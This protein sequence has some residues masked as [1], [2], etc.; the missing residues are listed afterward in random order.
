MTKNQLT[1]R[2]RRMVAEQG[3]RDAV[4]RLVREIAA[5]EKETLR[6]I[7]LAF[8]PKILRDIERLERLRA[9]ATSAKA[10]LDILVPLGNSGVRCAV[11]DLRE[12]QIR[13][14]AS[15]KA[16]FA[17]TLTSQ[18]DFLRRMAKRVGRGTVRI[19]W[20]KL[21]SA[22]RSAL[23]DAVG[24]GRWAEKDKVDAA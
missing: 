20:G 4:P 16:A 17:E 14:I 12:E 1:D 18:V 7:W 10:A 22:E 8:G 24:G 15:Q 13:V 11:G 6:E 9:M 23:L 2:L 5:A 19:V 3:F 21:T